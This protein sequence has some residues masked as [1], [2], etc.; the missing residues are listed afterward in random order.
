MSSSI[1]RYRQTKIVATLGP[2]S[3]E[4]DKMRA[5]FEA[6]VDV[7]RLNFSHGMHEAH[8]KNVETARALEKEKERPIALMADL[9]GPKLRIG[10]FEN[11][12]IDLKE[13]AS[14]R[15]DLDETPGNENRVQL[16]HPEIIE[17][18]EIGSEI[19]LDDG[20]VRVCITGKSA[21]AL[22]VKIISGTA[23][24]NNKG[25]NVPG[26]LLPVPALT[27]K[28]KED[29][30]AALNMGVDWIAQSFPVCVSP[31][32]SMPTS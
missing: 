10:R 15:F 24:S 25:F 3:G 30:E 8:A 20:K 28:D 29:L 22:D 11:G 12:K 1:R 16:P 6:G 32:K 13:G 18:M 17:I 9:Q 2:A 5:L 23:L 14:F 7:F 31:T 19:L 26:V 4:P 27:E 21:D